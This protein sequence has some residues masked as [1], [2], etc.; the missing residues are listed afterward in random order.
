[1]NLEF[2]R[3][4]SPAV[5]GD[6]RPF[7]RSWV[8]WF[9]DLGT[10]VADGVA[11]FAAH[12]A[13]TARAG[14]AAGMG[15]HTHAS[16]GAE[17]GQLDHG[18]ALTASSRTDDDHSQY[19][20]LAGR[21]GGQTLKGG[22]VNT[23][24]LFLESTA[25]ATKTLVGL[26][27]STVSSS[28]VSINA[29]GAG[30]RVSQL[31]FYNHDNAWLG[32]G[33]RIQQGAGDGGTFTIKKF[34]SGNLVIDA[35]GATGAIFLQTNDVT[36]ATI[37]SDG[38]LFV[39]SPTGSSKG[40]GSLNAVS[41]YIDG[42]AV[43]NHAAATVGGAPLTI[44][45]QQVTFN[46][47]SADFQ[48]SGNNLQVKD[49]GVDHAALGNIN[50]ASYTHLSSTDHT[51]LTDG[52]ATTLHKHDHGGQ[53]GLADD[54][55]GGYWWLTGRTGN[56]TA[57]GSIDSGGSLTIRATS[58]ATAG[59]LYLNDLGAGIIAGSL[60]ADARFVQ[61]TNSASGFSGKFVN[62]GDNADRWGIQA[63]CGADDGS[64]TTHYFNGADG[65][66]D[67]V[68]TI[69]NNAGTFALVDY[70]DETLKENI[71]PT[72]VRGLD[73]VRGLNLIEFSFKKHHKP[74]ADHSIGFSAQNLQAIFPEAV[75]QTPKHTDQNGNHSGSILG[76]SRGHL[77][78]VL[79]KA[80]QEM[81]DQMA[82][83]DARIAALEARR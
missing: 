73:V 63:Y 70:C 45:G 23:E 49:S 48:L 18:A 5:E 4:A 9:R 58:H 37:A 42:V 75:S 68:G 43:N 11:S 82:Q 64:G 1:M 69:Y 77:I 52:G 14:H 83:I 53:D 55:H 36:R 6:G 20:L 34:D 29:M 2:P 26:D 46:Y 3:V 51:D 30:D 15:D 57:Y 24:Y 76:V 12:I 67:W 33:A 16:A 54:D 21:A 27:N 79:I 17:G 31:D 66:G 81:A 47:D 44:S 60:S 65:N 71:A 78:P 72:K 22:L 32:L 28:V 50:S 35:S 19:A 59:V 7:H 25:H 61:R 62:D 80:L 40:A 74:K 39:G 10:T 13:G 38:G 8:R 41:L 56:K